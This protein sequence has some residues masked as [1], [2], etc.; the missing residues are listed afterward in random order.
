MKTPWNKEKAVGRMKGLTPNQ[1]STIRSIL[2][3]RDETRNVALLNVAVDT[4]LRS[5]DL[6]RLRVND[7]TGTDGLVSEEF[8]VHQT[9]TRKGVKVGLSAETQDSLKKWISVSGKSGDDYL[10]VLCTFVRKYT[11]R[12]FTGRLCF[13]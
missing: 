7:V 5:V 12:E 8:S 6:L 4:M 11:L 1:V 13:Y 10:R 2:F 3:E 9:K